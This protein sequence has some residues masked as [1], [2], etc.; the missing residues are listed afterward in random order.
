MA[1]VIIYGGGTFNHVRNH[2]SLAAPAFGTTAKRLGQLV[3]YSKV[4]LTK[5]ADS[6]SNILTGEDLKEDL[7]RRLEDKYTKC[8]IMNAALC[9]YN[10]SIGCEVSGSHQERLKS[11]E[12]EQAIV[13]TPA[14]KLIPLI[15]EIRPDVLVVG[16]KTTTNSDE[17]TRIAYSLRMA[18]SGVD[19]VLANDVVS[20]ENLIY[21]R[22]TREVLS[23]DSRDGALKSLALLVNKGLQVDCPV[24]S[25][26]TF[27]NYNTY[28]VE[29]PLG[30]STANAKQI[31]TNEVARLLSPAED[32]V[33]VRWNKNKDQVMLVVTKVKNIPAWL[34]PLKGDKIM[35][36]D[37]KGSFGYTRKNH[38]HEGVDLY[39]YEGQEV[40]AVEDGVVVGLEWFTGEK[41]AHSPSPWWNN[42]QALL[43]KGASGVVLYGEI[44]VTK[45]IGD[46]V[47]VGEV[48]GSL[49]RV[50]KK[51]K[52]RPTTMLHIELHESSCI[53][54]EAWDGMKPK[55][56]R[57]PTKCLESA[58]GAPTKRYIEPKSI[59]QSQYNKD[60]GINC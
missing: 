41:C 26:D 2:M 17:K 37:A 21:V 32:I 33:D 20:R 53:K 10:G 56:L 42:T 4:V 25:R 24:K 46:T 43:V 14:E 35:L 11:R 31:A 36:P 57:D 27:K 22:S 8:I 3:D 49:V 28:Y 15:K 60:F 52:G 5:M 39:G 7:L 44:S 47:F 19:L 16:F 51:D 13:L 38:T 12:G 50:L 23:F 55:T 18:E 40:Y 9:D 1:S 48:I 6:S 29:I 54:S 45:S 58:I 34:F 30:T 59:I